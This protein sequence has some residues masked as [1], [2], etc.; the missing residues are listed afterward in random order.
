MT[1]E[2]EDDPKGRRPPFRDEDWGDEVSEVDA[3]ELVE[4]METSQ[5]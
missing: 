5:A 2:R 3:S 4:E 1:D